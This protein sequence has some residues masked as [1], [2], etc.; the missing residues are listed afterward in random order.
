MKIWEF[1]IRVHQMMG[2]NRYWRHGQTA[3]NAASDLFSGRVDVNSVNGTEA[4][5]FY[6]DKNLPA[7]MKFLSDSGAFDD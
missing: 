5:P 6:N 3:Y 7:F 1:D 4:D 2:E